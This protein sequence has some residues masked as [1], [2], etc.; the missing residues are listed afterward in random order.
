MAVSFFDMLKSILFGSANT[1]ADGEDA[2]ESLLHV[3]WQQREESFYPG[4]FGRADGPQLLLTEDMFRKEFA[5]TAVHPFWLHHGIITFPPTD[6]RQ[7]W[8]YATSGM[9]NAFDSEEDEW[10]GLG[11]EFILETPLRESWAAEK[12]ARLMVFNLLIA[13]GHYH[14]QSD[15]TYGSIVRLDVPI[16]G[17]PT[18]GTP[19]DSALMD[20]VKGCC[21]K[22]FIALPPT[23]TARDFE[24]VT[25]KVELLQM[26]AISNAE[27]DFAEAEG[28]EA[29]AE[30]LAEAGQ[31]D[32]VDAD[33]VSVV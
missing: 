12:L 32:S 10:S 11:V 31:L 3:G 22:N 13:A 16:N 2:A 30:K 8:L 15:L 24:L 4:M 6:T 26:V 9:S 1:P 23:G 21:L 25:G 28:H 18:D 19:K 14:D 17:T 29:L 7:T 33:R 27:A 20:G 5:R